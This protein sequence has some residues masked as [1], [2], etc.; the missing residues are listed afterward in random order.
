MKPNLVIRSKVLFIISTTTSQCS[1]DLLLTC[2]F[3]VPVGTGGQKAVF[4]VPPGSRPGSYVNVQISS[5][6]ED[7]EAT[8]SPQPAPE[9]NIKIRNEDPHIEFDVQT[10]L[11]D[12]KAEEYNSCD[13]DVV[14]ASLFAG[15]TF[16]EM[17]LVVW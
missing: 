14:K 10:A 15:I 5:S 11:G 17:V 2:F 16:D 13:D 6:G 7:T 8:F 1:S 9:S 12:F 3:T 4:I